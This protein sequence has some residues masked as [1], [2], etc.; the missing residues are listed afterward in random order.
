MFVPNVAP[1]KPAPQKLKPM[2][3]DLQEEISRE[4]QKA[5]DHLSPDVKISVA[6]IQWPTNHYHV[7]VCAPLEQLTQAQRFADG[8][9]TAARIFHP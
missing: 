1:A 8:F 5:F 6:V 3:R 9:I 2:T 4:L 7:T